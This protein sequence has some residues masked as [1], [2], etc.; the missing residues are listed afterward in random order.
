MDTIINYYVV[1]FFVILICLGRATRK[2]RRDGTWLPVNITQ[3]IATTIEGVDEVSND[4]FDMNTCDEDEMTKDS[5]FLIRQLRNLTR[6]P[7][8][9]FRRPFLNRDN[10]R[11]VN[12]LSRKSLRFLRRQRLNQTVQTSDI[13]E[14]FELF[15][16]ALDSRNRD[17]WEELQESESGSEELLSNAEEYASITASLLQ[18]AGDVFRFT[19]ENLG[20]TLSIKY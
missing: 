15:N 16:N 4:M 11:S 14:V 7:P 9:R 1:F 5:I 12:S 19:D 13:S 8:R 6:P 10:L 18:E 3:C 20:K 17:S 2:C